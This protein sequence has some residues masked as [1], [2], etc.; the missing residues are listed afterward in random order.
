MT[1][2]FNMQSVEY[3]TELIIQQ[4]G[5]NTL[6]YLSCNFQN[7][8]VIHQSNIQYNI[9]SINGDSLVIQMKNYNYG[10]ILNLKAELI[11]NDYSVSMMTLTSDNKLYI[12]II[13]NNCLKRTE[14][15]F[16]GPKFKILIKKSRFM[17]IY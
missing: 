1:F 5:S 4:Q 6:F 13:N 15:I 12:D 16:F 7:L 8:N 10:E 14:K 3:L 9:R 2:N 17:Q 11:S